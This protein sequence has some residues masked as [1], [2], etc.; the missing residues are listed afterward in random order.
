VRA[1]AGISC[2]QRPRTAERHGE[3]VSFLARARR[4]AG[5]VSPFGS[6]DSVVGA[7]PSHGSAPHPY[8]AE[9]RPGFVYMP[10][11]R[12]RSSCSCSTAAPAILPA[13]QDEDED[14]LA[15]PASDPLRAAARRFQFRST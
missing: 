4:S 8:L 15:K 2:L 12:S 3:R 14:E 11:R 13:L 9:L 1:L 5:S 6:K 7:W 10:F